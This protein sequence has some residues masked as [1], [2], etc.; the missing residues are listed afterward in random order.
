MSD[1]R[2]RLDLRRS[3]GGIGNAFADR[4]FRLYSVGSLVSWTTYFVQAIAFS[5]IT[6]E[7]THS[8][9]W[10]AIV[11]LLDILANVAFLPLGGALADRHD[12]FKMVLIAYAL[13]FLK[14]VALALLAF[15]GNLTLFIV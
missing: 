8:T 10:L 1:P 11:A 12:R 7:L 13:D 5:W 14:A 4:N 6:W 9:L 3:L 15:T 2:S